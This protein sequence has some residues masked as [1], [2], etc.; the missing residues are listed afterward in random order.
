M[1]NLLTVCAALV[2][3]LG[4]VSG[5]LWTELRAAREEI[6]A[7]QE[8]LGQPKASVARSE[9][10]PTPPTAVSAPPAPPVAVQPPQP[11]PPPALLPPPRALV[12]VAPPERPIGQPTLT[13]PLI[14]NNAEERR[15]DA[16]EQSDRAAT[17]RVAAW[18]SALRFTP[19]QMQAVT[20]IT[21]AELRRETEESLQITSRTG[22]L[23]ARGAARLKV[24]TVIRQHETLL[25]I[26]EKSTPQLSLE[27][28][29]AMSAM[30]ARWLTTNMGR[31]KAEEQAALSGN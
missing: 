20:A 7:L 28:S 18:N 21:A 3:I 15:A 24:E 4:I 8:R 25:R 9:P 10:A 13:R 2:V 31:A 17:A 6:A 1:R 26:L 30:F 16:L 27:Q 19:E 23:D 11:G 5:N 12:P 22:P 14:G 29:D